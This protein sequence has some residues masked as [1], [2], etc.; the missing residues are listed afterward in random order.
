MLVSVNSCKCKNSLIRNGKKNCQ[1]GKNL[2]FE[3]TD[4]EKSKG[5]ESG[6]SRMKRLA[7]LVKPEKVDAIIAALRGLKLEATI[8]DVKGAGKEKER[9]T[10]GRGMGTVEL[11]YTSR[12][13][14][15]TV[16]DSE[17]VEDVVDAMRGALGGQSGG[18]LVISPVDD[19]VRL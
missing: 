4:D 18:V 1:M 5:K 6:G 11:A 16:V 9:V 8:Y 15:A 7:V 19:I 12:K 2:P 3:V 17:R 13:I 10:S 14:V